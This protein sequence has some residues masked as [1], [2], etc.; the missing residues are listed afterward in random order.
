MIFAIIFIVYVVIIYISI[1]LQQRREPLHKPTGFKMSTAISAI[2]KNDDD[3][4]DDDG[5]DPSR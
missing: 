3:D 4:D 2:Y 1:C 5:D